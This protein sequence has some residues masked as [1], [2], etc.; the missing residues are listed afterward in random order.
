LPVA[1]LTFEPL[2][3]GGFHLMHHGLAT[4]ATAVNLLLGL[5]NLLPAFPMDGGM[6]LRGALTRKLGRVAATELAASVGTAFAMVFA[7]IGLVTMQFLWLLLAGYIW[8]RGQA[9]LRQTKIIDRMRQSG[10]TEFP[11]ELVAL[12][13]GLGMTPEKLRETMSQG[14]R[15]PAGGGVDVPPGS[16]D[17]PGAGASAGTVP[18]GQRVNPDDVLRQIEIDLGRM[19]GHPAGPGSGASPGP[20][21]PPPVPAPAPA[22][23]GS[24]GEPR[25][26]T[27]EVVN[28]ETNQPGVEDSQ[29]DDAN[30]D[31]EG[32]AG[33][34]PPADGHYTTRD[35]RHFYK[36]Q[37]LL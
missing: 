16:P 20:G 35:G 12:M 32:M 36:G 26:V 17:S 31:A 1:V 24:D 8:V 29:T 9:E 18:G 11:P 4:W 7:V 28:V 6:V 37:E 5:F 33:D 14:R 34:S 30:S 15:S 10:L 22:A 3:G 27:I 19:F 25:R 2:P 21:Q 13:Q 23:A